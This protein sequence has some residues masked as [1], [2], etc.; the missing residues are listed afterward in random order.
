MPARHTNQ[1]DYRSRPATGVRAGV[2]FSTRRQRLGLLDPRV[3]TAITLGGGAEG[4][5][6]DGAGLGEAGVSLISTNQR[7]GSYG[8][9]D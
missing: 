5:G 6:L 8:D 7:N 9:D 2:R 4:I 3:S 1:V